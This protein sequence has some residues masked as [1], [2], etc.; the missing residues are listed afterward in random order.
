MR[1]TAQHG[2]VHGLPQEAAWTSKGDTGSRDAA[3]MSLA[4]ASAA[5][6][7]T[8]GP[9]EIRC[10]QGMLWLTRPGWGEDIVLQA[11]ERHVVAG[12][13]RDLL[14]SAV[15]R[16]DAAAFRIVPLALTS[17]GVMDRWRGQ[18]PRYRLTLA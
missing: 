15:T 6:L 14:L 7:D 11:G 5:V 18:R 2:F 12:A 8:A 4:P 1:M 9:V 13:A 16:R 3:A 10:L 17:G